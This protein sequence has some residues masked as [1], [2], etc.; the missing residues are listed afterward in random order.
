[1]GERERGI[2]FLER[3]LGLLSPQFITWAKNDSDLDNLRD[4]PRYQ[5][6]IARAEE[7][8]AAQ[9]AEPAAKAS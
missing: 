4:H 9:Q 7:R 2:D 1:M 8:L 5:V 3:S 6:L